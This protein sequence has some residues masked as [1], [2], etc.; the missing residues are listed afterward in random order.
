MSYQAFMKDFLGCL[1]L[2]SAGSQHGRAISVRAAQVRAPE[3]E[4]KAPQAIANFTP[5]CCSAFTCTATGGE[6]LRS[7]LIEP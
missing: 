4:L 5:L 1:H 7:S 6:D 2:L 3:F